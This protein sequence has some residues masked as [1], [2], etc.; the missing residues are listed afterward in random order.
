MPSWMPNRTRLARGAAPLGLALALM[1]GEAR[2][3]L[4]AAAGKIDITPAGPCWIAGY[5]PN[6]RSEGVHDPVWARALVLREGGER[7]AL[8]SCDVIGLNFGVIQR[9]RSAVKA[10]PGERVIV[11]STHT[12]SGPDT[13]GL[14]GPNPATSG[15]DK[16]WLSD[17][18]RRIAALVDETAARLKPATIAFGSVSGVKDCSYNARVAAILDTE[19]AALRVVGTDG[20]GIATLVNYAC[21][22]EVLNCRQVTSDFPHWLR[23]RLEERLG[24]VAL[25]F[26]GAQ[27][28][29]VTAVI[30]NEDRHPEGQAWPEA[31]RVG[32][33]L[34]DAA[35]RALDG[36]RPASVAP[37][38]FARRE[39]A[40]PLENSRFKALLASGVLDGAL[41]REGRILTEVAR[42]TVGPAE[43]ITLPG[44]VLPSIGLYLKRHMT[45]RPRFQ[46]GL[47]GDALGYILTPEDYGLELYRYETSMSV[48]SQMG[49]IME[50]HLLAL[51]AADRPA[52]AGR[53]ES[54]RP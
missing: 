10:V 32:L 27:G 52:A 43:F 31:E 17:V 8:V 38:Q 39:F 18:I 6:R 3:E 36:A 23:S 15:V 14:W 1:P 47:T 19:L 45:G 11:G 5:A 9:I 53:Q 22:P 16:A 7:L 12:H 44:E 49:R 33:T 42:F 20:A 41:T 25:Y 4:W 48:G 34:A 28:G 29:M 13:Q 26:N 35:L 46:L 50:D 2:G 37:I 21:H 30:Q 40:V 24:G 54:G 51:M